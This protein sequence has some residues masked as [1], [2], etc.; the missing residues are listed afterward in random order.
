MVELVRQ[1]ATIEFEYD[2]GERGT[3]AGNTADF[4]EIMGRPLPADA[5]YEQQQQVGTNLRDLFQGLRQLLPEDAAYAA[6]GRGWAI[7][8]GETQET[9][10]AIVDRPTAAAYIQQQ[11]EWQ[12]LPVA[13][14]QFM[15]DHIDA[16]MIMMQGVIRAIT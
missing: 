1:S 14:R 11:T 10:L 12:N 13:S 8:N 6:Y 5:E 9:I 16:V 7:K 4:E 2:D 3:F 15:V